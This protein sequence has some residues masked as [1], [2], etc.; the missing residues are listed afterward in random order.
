MSGK[1]LII[2]VMAVLVTGLSSC[3]KKMPDPVSE[4]TIRQE[5]VRLLA[6]DDTTIKLNSLTIDSSDVSTVTEVWDSVKATIRLET[7]EVM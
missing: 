4:E 7:E 1:K 6:I 5:I 3:V 2:I